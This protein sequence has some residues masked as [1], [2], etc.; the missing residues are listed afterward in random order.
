MPLKL[1]APD[2]GTDAQPDPKSVVEAEPE[3]GMA[4]AIDELEGMAE[5]EALGAD[6][7]DAEVPELPEL[8]AAAPSARPAVTTETATR[9]VFT[10]SPQ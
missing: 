9:R 3:D 1:P 4:E 7:D 6:D 5:D 8:H 10:F 2:L